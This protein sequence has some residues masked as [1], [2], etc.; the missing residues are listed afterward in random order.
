[1][2]NRQHKRTMSFAL[3]NYAY[4]FKGRFFFEQLYRGTA[5]N[6]AD[7]QIRIKKCYLDSLIFTTKPNLQGKKHWHVEFIY[8]GKFYHKIYK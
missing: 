1:M 2:S 5:T 8:N 7:S 6:L 3:K 4:F